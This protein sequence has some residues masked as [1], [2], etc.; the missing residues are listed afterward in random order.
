ML[1]YYREPKGSCLCKASMGIEQLIS[2]KYKEWEVREGD[3]VCAIELLGL[4][5][6]HP[7]CPVTFRLAHNSPWH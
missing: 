2:G 3:G 7:A 4:K 5:E 6:G 1:P